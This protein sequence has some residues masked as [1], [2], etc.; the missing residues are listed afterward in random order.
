MLQRSNWAV[1]PLHSQLAVPRT[2]P[3]CPAPPPLP[4]PGSEGL[5]SI[6]EAAS[7]KPSQKERRGGLLSSPN[8]TLTPVLQG[9]RN[10][11]LISSP[12]TGPW[13]SRLPRNGAVRG[14]PCEPPATWGILCPGRRLTDSVLSV[15]SQICQRS[16]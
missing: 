15:V 10:L 6:P 11:R 3:A 16:V 1:G 5:N 14:A 2:P 9:L 4:L 7:R 8:P 13:Q 12:T